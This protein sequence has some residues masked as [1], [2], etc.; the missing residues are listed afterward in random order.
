MNYKYIHLSTIIIIR[1]IAQKETIASLQKESFLSSDGAHN[2]PRTHLQPRGATVA[3][4][5]PRTST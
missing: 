1:V 4:F 3:F 5:I 2:L